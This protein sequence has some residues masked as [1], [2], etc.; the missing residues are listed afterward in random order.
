MLLILFYLNPYIMK[1]NLTISFIALFCLFSFNAKA[2]HIA[3]S[4]LTFNCIGGNDYEVVYS[5]YRDCSGI[6]MPNSIIAT[7]NSSGLNYMT[8]W[9]RQFRVRRIL[10]T[11]NGTGKYN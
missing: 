11:G 4:D 9:N 6:S 2:S 10:K 3:A 8:I 1:R 5:L 7:L